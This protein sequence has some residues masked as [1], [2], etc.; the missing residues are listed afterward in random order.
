MHP[1]MNGSSLPPPRQV[2]VSEVVG[3]MGHPGMAAIEHQ[4]QSLGLQ[5]EHIM[6]ADHPDAT[7][8]HGEDLDGEELEGEDNEEDPVK[9][10]VG[11]VSNGYVKELVGLDRGAGIA[12]DGES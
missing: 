11:Q 1:A 9:L 5:Q 6:G 8:E 12:K 10:F 3:G 7:D 4:F 2:Y